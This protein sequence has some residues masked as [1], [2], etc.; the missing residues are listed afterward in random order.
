M[1]FKP[2]KESDG[3]YTIRGSVAGANFNEIVRSGVRG[4]NVNR[5]IETLIRQE[6]TADAYCE[7]ES[8]YGYYCNRPSCPHCS[9][10]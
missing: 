1:R 8:T 7:N 6:R 9:N 10:K 4:C 2:V 5:T 3:T